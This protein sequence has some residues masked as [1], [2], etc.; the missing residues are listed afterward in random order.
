MNCI[1]GTFPMPPNAAQLCTTLPPPSSF[2]GP[3]VAVDQLIDIFNKIQL[4]DQ[5]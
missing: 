2:G 4:P 1:G 5:G 3:F